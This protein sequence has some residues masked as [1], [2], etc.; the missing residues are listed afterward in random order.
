VT[1]WENM[2]DEE[3]N[4]FTLQM[5]CLASSFVPTSKAL[6]LSTMSN[7]NVSLL[8]T[9]V[10]SRICTAY[11]VSYMCRPEFY[12]K[13]VAATLRRILEQY[14]TVER[15]SLASDA[16]TLRRQFL[17]LLQRAAF[18][19]K[20]EVTDTCAAALL[21]DVDSDYTPRQTLR[22]YV[23]QNSIFKY[24]E[25]T[26]S[27]NDDNDN[28]A[29]DLDDVDDLPYEDDD[30]V[31]G[32]LY[33]DDK[34]ASHAGHSVV[35]AHTSDS[36]KGI[37]LK[38]TFVEQYMVRGSRLQH[39]SPYWYIGII[40]IATLEKTTFLFDDDFVLSKYFGQKVRRRLSAFATRAL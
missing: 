7:T 11:V 10:Q 18:S 16:D 14:S 4:A 24:A 21:L 37:A 32:S 39:L 5:Q 25:K 38:Y 3:K 35:I 13:Q 22:L 30:V 2:S 19:R 29:I 23:S 20:T 40:E 17:F 12:A 31:I 9:D 36:K 6:C 26:T 27:T 33:A 28:D 15:V 1:V 8:G 34:I